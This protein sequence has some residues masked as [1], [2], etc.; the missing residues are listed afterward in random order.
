MIWIARCLRGRWVNHLSLYS[1]V[2]T[3]SLCAYQLRLIA[4]NYI[5]GE[6]WVLIF[7]AW[8][9]LYLGAAWAGMLGA[10]DGSSQ[11]RLVPLSERNLRKAIVFLSCAGLVSSA[12]LAWNI[13]HSLDTWLLLALVDQGNKIYTMRF[14]GELSGLMYVGFLPYAASALA[15]A[16]AS[17]MGRITF[18]SAL[19]LLAMTVDGILSMQRGGILIAIILFVAGAWFTPSRIPFRVVRWQ[20]VAALGLLLAGFLY[21]TMTRGVPAEF[22]NQGATLNRVSDV[23]PSFPSLY[24]Y[25]SAPSAGL[26][27]YLQHPESDGHSFWGRYTFAPAYRF[28]AKLGLDTYVPYYTEF[29]STPVP[30]NSCTYLRE[31]H[32]DFGSLGV[33]GVPFCLGALITLLEFRRSSLTVQMVLAHLYVVVLFSFTLLITITGY[34]YISLMASS[35]V[36]LLLDWAHKPAGATAFMARHALGK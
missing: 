8:I 29:Y 28:F 20:M 32:S 27:A 15:G 11:R 35:M 36:G 16:Y 22:E 14:E 24:M 18:V 30:I 1:F 19:P 17:R 9:A 13:V 6:A 33:L 31:I 4:Y 3:V 2:W 25:I 34:W 26:S 12:A 7:A 23:V 5:S 21:V 10:P